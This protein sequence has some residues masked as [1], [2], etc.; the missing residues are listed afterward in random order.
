MLESVL[1]YGDL[2]P[3]LLGR[4]QKLTKRTE[5]WNAYLKEIPSANPIVKETDTWKIEKKRYIFFTL[6]GFE[7]GS[8]G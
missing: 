8:P 6:L 5:N 7:P 3:D 4:R 1:L 2:N